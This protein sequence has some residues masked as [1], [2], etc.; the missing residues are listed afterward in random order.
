MEGYETVR[1]RD[2]TPSFMLNFEVKPGI[3]AGF[4]C[5]WA[6]VWVVFWSSLFYSVAPQAPNPD[7]TPFDSLGPLWTFSL[8]CMSITLTALFG[9]AKR[10]SPLGSHVPIILLAALPTALGTAIVAEPQLFF[11]ESSLVPIYYAGAAVLG[12]GSAFWI[13][14]WGEALTILGSRQSIVY[15]VSSTVVSVVVYALFMLAGPTFARLGAVVFPL[16]SM[17]LFNRER[18]SFQKA[19]DDKTELQDYETAVEG[20]DRQRSDKKPMRRA[21]VELLLISLFFGTSYGIMKGLFVVANDDLLAIRDLTNIIAM[22][23]GSV[24]IFVTMGYFRMDFRRLT[25]QIALPLM[26][27]GFLLF[28]LSSPYQMVGFTLHQIGYQYF[29]AI[30]WAMWPVLALQGKMKA[31]QFPALSLLG[32]QGGQLLGSYVGA[33]IVGTST[34]SYYLAEVSA[35]CVFIVLLV[36]LFGFGNPGIDGGWI[37]LRPFDQA[38]KPR[39]RQSLAKLAAARG[40]SPRETEVFDMLARGRNKAAIAKSLT[41]SESTVKTH[42]KNIYRK[43]GVHSQQALLDMIELDAKNR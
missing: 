13:V 27:V 36:A 28:P 17:V 8:L 42:I 11:S 12:F 43:M 30:I 29:Y 23:L 1:L 26:A 34:A 41:I 3:I 38:Q 37:M 18:P 32:V 33:L 14:L 21:L 7:A 40:L 2:V 39:F 6:W 31:A 4:S 20:Q 19:L 35:F 22:I 9:A 5:Y 16:L 15:F 25:Y 24:A 10:Y